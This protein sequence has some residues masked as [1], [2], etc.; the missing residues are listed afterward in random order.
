MY[1]H[2]TVVEIVLVLALRTVKLMNMVPMFGAFLLMIV[3]VVVMVV[4]CVVSS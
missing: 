1:I 3:V 2:L 4:S